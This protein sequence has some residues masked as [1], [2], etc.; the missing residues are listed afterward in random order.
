MRT[1]HAPLLPTIAVILMTAAP[2]AA[3]AQQSPSAA[4][5]AQPVARVPSEKESS[6]DDARSDAILLSPFEVTAQSDVGYQAAETLAGNRMRTDLR[7]IGS[8]ITVANEAFLRDIGATNSEGLLQ[9]LPSTEVGGGN[10]N[11][12]VGTSVGDAGVLDD[13]SARMKPQGNTRV[14]GLDSADNTRDFFLTDIPWD[15]YNTSRI[16]IQRGANSILFGNGS[17]AGIINGTADPAIIGKNSATFNTKVGIYGSIRGSLNMN[18]DLVPGQV[19]LRVAALTDEKKY[20]QKPAF[21]H[22]ERYYVALRIDPRIFSKGSARTSLKFNF[23]NGNIDANRPRLNTIN[24]AISPW[25]LNTAVELRSPT[26]LGRPSGQDDTLLGV[27][28]PMLSHAGYDP[29]VTGIN[30][31]SLFTANPTR[32]DIGARQAWSA[33]NPN[34]E[35]W[36]GAQVRLTDQGGSTLG[37]SIDGSGNP[38]WMAVYADPASSQLSNYIYPAVTN[39]Y[40]VS[41][42]TG[43]VDNSTINGFRGPDMTG[44]LRLDQYASRGIGSFLY[45]L[46]GVWRSGTVTDPTVFDYYN[47]LLDGPNKSERSKFHVFNATLDQTFLND[48]VGFQ[49]AFD[50][51]TYSDYRMSNLA[52]PTLRLDIYRYLPVATVNATSG[53]L[54]PVLNPN[55]GRPYVI[56]KPSAA[57]SKSD[58][59]VVRF[60][61]FVSLDAKDILPSHG[62]LAGIL[63]KHTLTGLYEQS[64]YERVGSSWIPYTVAQAQSEAIFGPNWEV[65]S[66]RRSVGTVNYLGGSLAAAPTLSGS[67]LSAIT[68]VQRPGLDAQ[69]GAPNAWYFNSNY[70]SALDPL[71]SYTPAALGLAPNAIGGSAIR[72]AENPL[73]YAAWGS[74]PRTLLVDNAMDLGETAL[75]TSAT[76]VKNKVTSMAF[77]DQWKLLNNHLVITAGMRRDKV[78]TYYPGDPS[79]PATDASRTGNRTV[80]TGTTGLVDWSAPFSYASSPTYSFTSKWMKTYG[81]V[82]HLPSA[83]T[84]RTPFGVRTSLVFNSSENFRPE[85]RNDPITGASIEPPIGRTREMGVV[86]STANN[87]ASLKINWYQTKVRNATLPDNGVIGFSADEVVQGLR[88]AMIVLYSQDVNNGTNLSGGNPTLSV[89]NPSSVLRGFMYR[90]TAQSS[91]SSTNLDPASTHWYPWQPSNPAST[92]GWTL[93]EWKNAEDHAVAAAQAF[94][95]SLSSPMAQQFLKTWQIDPKSFSSTTNNTYGI[96]SI[97]PGGVRVTGDTES[98]GTEVELFLSPTRNWDITLNFAKTFAT[99][100]NLAGNVSQWIQDRWALYNAAYTGAEGGLL[101]GSLRWFSHG[102]GSVN[103]ANARYG[104]NGYRFYSEFNSKEGVNVAE[105]RPYRANVVTS[106]K[107]TRG[108]VKGAFAGASFRWEDR[109]IIGYGVTETDP[110][111]FLTT[112][113]GVQSARAAV[114]RLDV[115][116]PFYGKAEGHLGLWVGYNRRN[117]FKKVD[118]RTQFSLSNVGESTKL[119]AVTVNPDGSGAAYRIAQGMGWEWSNTF[120]F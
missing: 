120:K 119:V 9:Y 104:R 117:L 12:L 58:R 78:E 24:D 51:Q 85:N 47:K 86:F 18:T 83:V 92:A 44:M 89:N 37:P 116:K 69:E 90:P 53:L 20:Q 29:F 64:R 103:A 1:T 49:L 39:Y 5:G 21:N 96:T 94:L 34:A 57:R 111:L 50:Q 56:S 106:Y 23:E 28:K 60:T 22:D 68:A 105:M 65:N 25:F 36:L 61:P 98:K 114:G 87:R 93:Q 73:N 113:S 40:A 43:L 82:L 95:G 108:W 3:F 33:T 17:G 55:F 91:T 14:R 80:L 11:F 107:F 16:D 97:T 75:T 79:K 70:T 63:G 32:M 8:A 66:T 99:R 67:N 101:A 38:Y 100:R 15:G 7:D 13:T 41:G 54:E 74:S 102:Q 42:T 62:R 59:D 71:A 4:A 2:L 45:A 84:R 27:M 30:T 77:V 10:G 6:G 46:Q 88:S 110:E 52:S 19:A 109:S 115:N 81:A 26:S 72:Q 112:S 76:Q 118:W 48:R 31:A 35:A